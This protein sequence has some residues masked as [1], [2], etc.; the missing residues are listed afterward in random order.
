MSRRKILAHKGV[1]YI[2]PAELMPPYKWTIVLKD[3]WWFDG[4]ETVTKNVESLKQGAEM[5]RYIEEREL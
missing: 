3:G 2:E 5:L 1:D 4:Y